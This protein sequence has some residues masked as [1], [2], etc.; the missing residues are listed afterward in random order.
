[1][2]H[3]AWLCTA[4]MEV[5]CNLKNELANFFKFFA[6]ILERSVKTYYSSFFLGEKP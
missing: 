1:M 6:R 2:I 5:D 4:R 3:Y